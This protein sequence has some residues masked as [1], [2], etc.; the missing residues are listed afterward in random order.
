ATS[1]PLISVPSSE[2]GQGPDASSS[3]GRGDVY[4]S[5]DVETDGPVPGR[6]SMLSFALV[7]AGTYDGRTFQRSNF[8]D[9]MYRELC[10]ISEAFQPEALAVNGLDRERLVLSGKDPAEV[11]TEASDWV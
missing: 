3:D 7:V 10:P 6:F 8:A 11:M 2:P 5:A 4:F 9:T 1:D